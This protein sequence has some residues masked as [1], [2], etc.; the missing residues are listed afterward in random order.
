M[1]LNGSDPGCSQAFS[2]N[3]KKSYGEQM[4]ITPLEQWLSTKIGIGCTR[5][6]EETIRSYQLGKLR[7]TLDYVKTR[8]P[9]YKNH[10][11]KTGIEDILSLEDIDRIPFTTPDDLRRNPLQFL[12]VSREDTNRLVTLHTPGTTGNPKRVYLTREDQ[13]LTIDFFQH[14]MSNLVQPGYRTLIFL[15]GERPGSIGHLLGIGF[16]RCGAYGMF[17]G[18]IRDVR[19]TLTT[20]EKKSINTLVGTPTEILSL[21]R[22]SRGAAAPNNI[23]L[24]TA[25]VPDFV[26]REL[27]NIW[28]CDVY[29]HYGL[30]ETAFGGGTECDARNGYHMQEADLY[31]EIVD[32][33]TGTPLKRGEWGEVVVTTLTRKG[34]PLIRYRTGDISRFI[35][36][37]CPCGTI[38]RTM[39]KVMGRTQS[40]V[41]PPRSMVSNKACLERELY[42]IC[43]LLGFRS[44]FNHNTVSNGTGAHADDWPYVS[45]EQTH[46][47][48]D[49]A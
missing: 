36:E 42:S 29:T 22:Y 20:L 14:S 34:M 31:F 1:A 15:H 32:P 8:S 18:P 10:L 38:L 6:T 3:Q 44:I 45:A 21:A 41:V 49:L 12:C 39:A 25:C 26:R 47:A 43:G 28:G 35:P 17:H 9:F 7:E 46:L 48:R 13:E 4:K 40:Y 19:T 11:A 37:P 27:R 23:L 2:R 16:K 30:T 5:M 33:K 24:S